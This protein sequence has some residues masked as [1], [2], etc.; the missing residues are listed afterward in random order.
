MAKKRFMVI[1][2]GKSGIATA[3]FLQAKQFDFALCD[4]RKEPPEVNYIKKQFKEVP[5]FLGELKQEMFADIDELIISPGLS[6]KLPLFKQLE[7]QGKTIIGDV[8]LFL[9]F[10]KTPVCAITGSNAKST[11]TTLVTKMAETAG[12]NV[13][14]GG[15]IGTPVL[16]LLQAPAPQLYVLELS[17]FQLETTY[18]LKAKAAT[19]LNICPDHMDRYANL[20]EYINAKQVIYHNTQTCVF[21]RDDPAT[22]VKSVYA[23]AKHRS[24]GLQPQ[25]G[26]FGLIRENGEIFLSFGFE[27]LMNI[28]EMLQVGLHHAQNA[29]AALSLGQACGLP[30]D[31]MLQTL[32]TFKGLKHR[33]QLVKT[34][35]GVSWY[36]DSKGTNEGATQAAIE[37]IGECI[38][39]K[40]I[41]LAGGVG[42][43]A[44]FEIL[45]KP[46]ANYVK[47]LILFGEAKEQLKAVLGQLTQT[48]VVDDLSEAIQMAKKHAQTGDSVLLSPACASFDMFKNFEDRGEIFERL[49]LEL[50]Q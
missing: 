41:L 46:V 48:L 42:K 19:I 36:N 34:H 50:V 28:K 3:E 2:L 40:V 7:A 14:M 12:V 37:S 44:D 15:N 20:Q 17:S 13:K 21:N 6:K 30:L 23:T 31:A 11:V 45:K 29:L 9:K 4:T 47:T 1:G 25:E 39:G 38:S 18:S 10:C 33:C 35:Q 24:F 26:A 49:V 22:F 32:K 27:K 16:Q 8:E 43:G 5:L